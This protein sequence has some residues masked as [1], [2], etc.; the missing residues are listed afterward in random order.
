MVPSSPRTGGRRSLPG[1][2]GAKAGL[3]EPALPLRASV[4]AI[5]EAIDPAAVRPR[6]EFLASGI[7]SPLAPP[8]FAGGP[9][10]ARPACVRQLAAHP[11]PALVEG[12]SL[13]FEDAAFGDR[14]P[15]PGRACPQ[16][17]GGVGEVPLAGRHDVG[18]LLEAFQAEPFAGRHGHFLSGLAVDMAI[19]MDCGIG[20]LEGRILE[21]AILFKRLG[22]SALKNFDCLSI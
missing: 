17:H 12:W 16:F 9:A 14:L 4:A 15:Q 10:R 5:G 3:R 22:L 19:L 2:G 11:F 13:G 7:A 8:A 1:L 21:L 18:Q 6:L 20:S